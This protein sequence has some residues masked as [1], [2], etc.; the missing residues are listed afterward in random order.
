MKR[1]QAMEQAMFASWGIALIATAGSLFFSEV[2]KYIPCDLC[3][4]Q[5]ILMYPLVILLGVASAKKDYKM[6][7]YTLILSVIGGLIS[8]Y[9]YLIQKV[10][11]LHELGNACGIVP[12]NSDYINWLGFITIPFLAL[13]AFALIIVLQIIVLKNG[14]E[15]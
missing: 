11:A 10:P 12:C 13:I 14:K 5:R 8:L 15:Q 9:H 2:L 3:W 4:Y 7:L 1:A 6:S